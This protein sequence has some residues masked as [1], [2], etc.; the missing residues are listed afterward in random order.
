M[1][2]NSTDNVVPFR[3]NPTPT[4]QDPAAESNEAVLIL[5]N[6]NSAL[7]PS[8]GRGVVAYKRNNS[9]E[10]NVM[11]KAT[12][13][14]CRDCLQ[15]IVPDDPDR[16]AY[17]TEL[18]NHLALEKD[19]YWVAVMFGLHRV[20]DATLNACLAGLLATLATSVGPAQLQTA[21]FAIAAFI[22]AHPKFAKIKAEASL[23]PPFGENTVYT[24]V[25]MESE[26]P[27]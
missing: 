10:A 20:D 7:D 18:L 9:E 22:H 1:K 14:Y 24:V 12:M 2:S 17:G 8:E 19:K 11:R 16:Y 27:A 25:D 15:H 4:G 3:P 13:D 5:R 21:K 23:Q 6:S 26:F